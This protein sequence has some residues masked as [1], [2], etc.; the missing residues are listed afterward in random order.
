ME[1][2]LHINL[3]ELRTIR[4][5]LKAFLPSIKGRLVQVFRQHRHVDCTKQGGVWSWTLCQ[6]A[7]LLW[8]WL[9][10]QGIFLVVRHLAGSLNAIVDK[11]AHRQLGDHEWRMHPEAQ[12]LFRK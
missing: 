6:E 2:R 5:A 4:L 12:D 3:L 11:L 9:E 8:T 1:A 10:C 7:L